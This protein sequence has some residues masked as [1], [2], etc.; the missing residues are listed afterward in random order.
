MDSS[1]III[2]NNEELNVVK[3]KAMY[4]TGKYANAFLTGKDVKALLAENGGT[5]AKLV[6]TVQSMT[7][8][9]LKAL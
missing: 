7:I 1:Q 9:D 3:Q 6:E 4:Y 8:E 5:H 2:T